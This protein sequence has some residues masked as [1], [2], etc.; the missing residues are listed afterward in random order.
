MR[1]YA[2]K[3]CLERPCAKSVLFLSIFVLA[4]LIATPTLYSQFNEEHD[5]GGSGTCG[6]DPGLGCWNCVHCGADG[7]SGPSYTCCRDAGNGAGEG[8]GCAEFFVEGIFTDGTIC[9]TSGGA[10]YQV[11]VTP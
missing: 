8:I 10:C 4:S 11:V 9:S 2:G 3:L 5:D 6:S 1:F 7:W